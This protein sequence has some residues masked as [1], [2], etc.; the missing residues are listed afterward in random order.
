MIADDQLE[1]LLD[2][3]TSN[4]EAGVFRAGANR[5]Q[6]MASITP[7]MLT[8]GLARHGTRHLYLR[9]LL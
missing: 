9:L 8:D 4:T 3:L 1:S 5:P 2:K 7:L 6:Q